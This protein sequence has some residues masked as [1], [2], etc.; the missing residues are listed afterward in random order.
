MRPDFYRCAEA[1]KELLLQQDI[2]STWIDIRS[3]RYQKR[4]YF[5]S[6]ENYCLV[7]GM[8]RREVASYLPDGCTLASGS[9]YIV[10]YHNGQRKK[11]RLNFT[12][13]HEIGHIY[14][15]HQADGDLEE[16][17]ANF[18]AAELLMPEPVLRYL[19]RQNNGLCVEDLHEWFYVTRMA[20]EKRLRTLKRKYDLPSP[21]DKELLRRFLPYLTPEEPPVWA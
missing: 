1:A 6:F 5:D 8:E 16:I 3:L 17:E 15:G 9:S 18:F 2:T 10:L 13:A 19:M 14:L 20:A 4:I 7:T 12:L 11:D 21:K